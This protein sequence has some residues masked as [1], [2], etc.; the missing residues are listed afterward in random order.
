MMIAQLVA[1]PFLIFGGL[2]LFGG[3]IGLLL[4]IFW[5]EMLIDAVTNDAIQGTE[6]IV[7]VLVI[8][9]THFVGALI[10]FFVARGGRPRPL[11]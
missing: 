4:M 7:W 6:K 2:G 1:N 5:L 8:I 11:V 9:F 3:L 10:Y